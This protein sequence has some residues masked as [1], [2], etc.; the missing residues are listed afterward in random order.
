MPV[1]DLKNLKLTELSLVD[2][3]ANEDAK[4]SIFKRKDMS[5]NTDLEK[6]VA[7]LT[8]TL[9]RVTKEAALTD[10]EKDFY[11]SAPDKDAFLALTVEKRKEV[12]E[13]AKAADE[14]LDING[15]RVSKA[16][17][18]PEMFEILK[19]QSKIAKDLEAKIEKVNQEATEAVLKARLEANEVKLEKRAADEFSHLSISKEKVVGILKALGTLDEAVRTDIENI[20]KSAEDKLG[21]AYTNLGVTV[22]KTSSTLEDKV[23]EVKKLYNLKDSEAMRKVAIDYPELIV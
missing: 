16:A 20:M 21:K 13:K 10:V 5:E 23:A 12:I 14:I 22:S 6:K 2:F 4:V 7:D 9:D 15:V 17:C 8:K 3:G 18:S 19:M 11:K 1:Y